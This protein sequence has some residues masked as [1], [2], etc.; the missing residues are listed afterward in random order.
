[1]FLFNDTTDKHTLISFQIITYT[2]SLHISPLLN[3][4]AIEKE[5]KRKEKKRKE[6]REREKS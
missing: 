5:K 4:F 3:C 2:Y 1:M 6:K